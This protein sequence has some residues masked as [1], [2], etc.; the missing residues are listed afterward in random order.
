[1][2]VVRKYASIM[3]LTFE[4]INITKEDVDDYECIIPK[5]IEQA[6]FWWQKAAAQGNQYAVDLQQV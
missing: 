5:D 6:K 1:M 3:T 2:E 4:L